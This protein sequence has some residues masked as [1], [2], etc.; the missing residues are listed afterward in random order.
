MAI[1]YVQSTDPSI[2]AGN[3]GTA[4]ES[5]NPT[6]FSYFSGTTDNLWVALVGVKSVSRQTT[7]PTIFTGTGGEGT[8]GTGAA[9]A[10]TGQTRLYF[11]H[12]TVDGSEPS[13]DSLTWTFG[14]AAPAIMTLHEFS[15]D[16]PGSWSVAHAFGDDASQSTG[17]G[18]IDV[19][20][21]SDPGFTAGDVAVVAMGSPTDA[22]TFS[23]A[24]LT[25]PGCT[26][27]TLTLRGDYGTT[28]GNDGGLQVWTAPITAGTSSGNPQL[29]CD[30]DDANASA[31]PAV[32]VRLREPVASNLTALPWII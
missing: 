10:D 2:T 24:A 11:W 8:G 30:V 26:I 28:A 16:N 6:T 7:E 32:F 13:S 27:G 23:N 3:A 22:G 4:Y 20:A 9:G 12:R 14:T 25:I 21:G 5:S 18:A 19:T 15:R 17:T 29:V 31:G 1:T